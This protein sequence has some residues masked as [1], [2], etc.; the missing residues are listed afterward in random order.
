LTQPNE[1]GK[2]LFAK[3]AA[4]DGEFLAE[5]AQMRNRPAE[6]GQAKLEKDPKDFNRRAALLDVRL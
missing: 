3:P 6:G 4:P 2:G 1:T 5:I